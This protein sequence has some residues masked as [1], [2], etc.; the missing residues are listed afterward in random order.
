MPARLGFR[1]RNSRSTERAFFR[2]P[3]QPCPKVAVVCDTLRVPS[4]CRHIS[5]H[6]QVD[7]RSVNAETI[8]APAGWILRSGANGWTPTYPMIVFTGTYHGFLDNAAR[9]EMWQRFGVPVF[10][11]L[12][13]DQGRVVASECEAH[14]GLHL[15]PLFR[16]SF[17][18]GELM[19]NGQPTGIATREM[20]GLCGCGATETRITDALRFWL[21][22]FSQAFVA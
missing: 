16:R 1:L 7:L 13:D 2:Y 9:D 15:D 8:A 12:L 11:Q 18:Q 17:H 6:E 20:D 5:E 14:A 4:G 21:P 22:S 10:E 3:L 19:L